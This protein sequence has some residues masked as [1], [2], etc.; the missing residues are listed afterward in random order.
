MQPIPVPPN[1]SDPLRASFGRAV[2]VALQE[3]TVRAGPGLY[4][5]TGPG[6]TVI[7]LLQESAPGAAPKTDTAI[8][9]AD[10]AAPQLRSV[11][12]REAAKAKEAD[13]E[14]GEG[15]APAAPAALQL[16]DFDDPAPENCGGVSATVTVPDGGGTCDVKF[17]LPGEAAPASGDVTFAARII[18]PETGA[19]S[20]A[21]LKLGV[22]PGEEDGEGGD[23]GPA[24]EPPP[25]GNPL[26]GPE[27]DPTP[28]SESDTV[29]ADRDPPL[30]DGD[31]TPGD[32]GK[33]DNPLDHPGDGGYT[34][35]CG[36]EPT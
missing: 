1:P 33:T 6:G 5:R 31:P 7:G 8:A 34:P 4:S 23:D 13:P 19:R 26:N 3:R 9:D 10:E 22:A 30:D 18:D 21:W 27:T 29:I 15:A 25:C 14:T 2:V 17:V 32:G 24:E 20:L 35:A 11:D 36:G 28:E 12:V 16:F